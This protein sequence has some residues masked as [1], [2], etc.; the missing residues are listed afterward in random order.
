MGPFCGLPRIGALRLPAFLV[1]LLPE[2]TGTAEQRNEHD[3]Q[4]EIR[5]RAHRVAGKHAKT[6]GVR[7]YFHAEREL[8]RDV[9]YVGLRKKGAKL[10]HVIS[11]VWEALS[12]V[13]GT[14]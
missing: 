6:T 1:D 5:A 2:I 4:L 11:I 3:R 14:A 9:R 13:L 10:V 7:M 12:A 8:H